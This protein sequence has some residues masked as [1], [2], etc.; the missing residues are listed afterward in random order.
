MFG[1]KSCVACNRKISKSFNF[2]PYCGTRNMKLEDYGML[3]LEDNHNSHQPII[4]PK[5][6]SFMDS[7]IDRAM[8][9]AINMIEKD[10]QRE[11][12]SSQKKIPKQNFQIMINGQKIDPASLGFASPPKKTVSKVS[13]LFDEEKRKKLR[14]LPEKEPKINVR[15]LSNKVLYELDIPGVNSLED[16]SINQLEDSIEIKAISLKNAY[17]KLIPVSLP[18]K[19]YSVSRGKLTLE[20]ASD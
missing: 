8:E 12:G 13:K 17:K 1:K 15:R 10:F 9:S 14:E 5:R 2:C 16:V 3:G 20:L 4:A 11:E 6:K 7:I 19:H 18:I